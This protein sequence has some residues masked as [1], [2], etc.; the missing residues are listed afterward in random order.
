MLS[1][2]SVRNWSCSARSSPASY[3]QLVEVAELRVASSDHRA[4]HG[5]RRQSSPSTPSTMPAI[6]IPPFVASPRLARPPR[7]RKTPGDRGD[8]EQAADDDTGPSAAPGCEPRARRCRAVPRR[9]RLLADRQRFRRTAGRRRAG[10]VGMV[11]ERGAAYWGLRPLAQP[12]R[13]TDRPG[14][15]TGACRAAG[16][17]RSGSPYDSGRPSG[18][19]PGGGAPGRRAA[20][21]V[22]RVRSP[23]VLPARRHGGA[24]SWT[25]GC[26]HDRPT[27]RARSGTR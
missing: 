22:S 26:R 18:S 15:R 21:R 13:L 12:V 2:K 1:S 16:C 7:P 24:Q 10:C 4:E 11:G 8:A 19:R 25:A 5:Q 14:R 3:R 23:E 17:R 27:R 6:A 9:R 20:E